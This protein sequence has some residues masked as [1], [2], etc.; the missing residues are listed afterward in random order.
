MINVMYA[1]DD[2]YAEIM[3]VSILSLLES[4]P[5]EK[6]DIYIIQDEIKPENLEKLRNMIE[7]K[8]SQVIF[9]QKPD[10][11][12]RLG[13]K[14]DDVRWSDSTYS[15]LF[16][17]DLFEDF[18]SVEKLLY[19]DCDIII[20]DSVR[21][22]WD[23]D[24]TGYLGAACPDP[25]SDWHKRILGRK[26]ED[27]Y[28][29]AGMILFNVKKWIED[30]VASR[31]TAYVKKYHGKTEYVDQGVINGTIVDEFLIL[32]PKYN[33]FTVAYDFNYHDMVIYRKPYEK[34]DQEI[35]EE[36]VKHPVIVHFTTSFLSLRPWFE[37]STHP[38]AKKWKEIHDRSP[39][40][41]EPYRIFKNRGRKEKIIKIYRALPNWFSVRVAGIAHAYLKPLAF[42]LKY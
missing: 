34:P 13:V 39:W 19:L 15:R 31:L 11:R 29:N 5:D 12:G 21:E 26:K 41:D 14:F 23:T 36:A 42:V 30:D 38:Y 7:S 10:I 22:L 1:S 33:M 4:N 28:I 37:G 24:I 40:K 2:N 8:G 35:W 25:L 17:K 27:I 3:G 18:P 20:V 32:P 16:L 6:F 9:L